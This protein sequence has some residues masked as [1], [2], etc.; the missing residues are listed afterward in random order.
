M[1]VFI[2]PLKS[3]KS[4]KSWEIV[5]K[6][7]ERCIKSICNQTSSEF[8]VIVVHHEKPDI[9]FTHP[10]I[11]YYQANFPPPPEQHYGLQTIDKAKKVVTALIFAQK[12][13]PSHVMI[14]D[15]D[16]CISKYL[17]EF[18]NG[19]HHCYGWFMD[20]GYEYQE[21]S[22]RIYLRRK[23]FYKLCGTSNIIKAEMYQLPESTDSP[24]LENY[25]MKHK[26]VRKI[27]AERDVIIEPLPFV[28]TVYIDANTGEN[29]STQRTIFNI[30]KN[31]PRVL[32]R[33]VKKTFMQTFKS[34]P[35]TE[36]IRNE[37]FLYP[38]KY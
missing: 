13:H 23:K 12:F 10:S 35:L 16:D 32:W 18:V 36:N 38:I 15:A 7:F 24:N 11:S 30:I 26:S 28:G 1:L 22:N 8:R 2:V 20:K 29:K 9:T 37:F 21:G 3:R 34:Q 27:L 5:S 25:Y 14:V 19:N 4:S 33:P 6:L 31:N 17:A